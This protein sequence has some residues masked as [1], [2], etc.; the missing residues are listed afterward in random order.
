MDAIRVETCPI[1]GR[2][3]SSPFDRRTF[4]GYVVENRVCNHCG[5][6]FQSPR[7]TDAALVEFYEAE[8]RRAYQGNEGPTSKDLFVQEKRSYA[9]AD[10]VKRT[11]VNRSH[12]TSHLDIGC[13]SGLLL[14]NFNRIFGLKGVGVEPGDAYRNYARQQG[15]DVRSSIDE[16]ENNTPGKFDLISLIHVLEHIAQ[17][18]EY[19]TDLAKNHLSEDGYL[20]VE[21]PNLYMH[22]SFEVAHLI[23][24]SPHMLRQVLQAAGFEVIAVSIHG[25]PRSRLL[26]LYITALAR[27]RC[28]PESQEIK[29]ENSIGLKRKIGLLYRKIWERLL[30]G[31]A[32]LP[33]PRN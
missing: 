21:V 31:Q 26:H 8:Y 7:M 23:S 6:V 29:P 5:C 10:F 32:W 33:L 12:L 27:F 15:L 3:T 19:L 25:K 30:P 24:F 22:D 20:L 1:C 4:K 28:V 13:S 2:S 16:L 9:L 18:V 14:Q 17:P 11:I